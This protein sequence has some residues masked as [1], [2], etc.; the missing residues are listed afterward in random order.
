MLT[1]APSLEKYPLQD[2]IESLLETPLTNWYVS[3]LGLLAKVMV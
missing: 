2:L 3:S 1:I